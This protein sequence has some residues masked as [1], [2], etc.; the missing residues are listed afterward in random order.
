MS[1]AKKRNLPVVPGAV[2]AFFLAACPAAA[3]STTTAS[4]P[5]QIEQRVDDKQPRRPAVLEPHLDILPKSQVTSTADKFS[6]V[7][8]AVIID[9]ATAFSRADLAPLYG[10]YLARK[11][12][13]VEVQEIA[14]AVTQVYRDAGYVFSQADVPVQDV[15]AGVLKIRVTEG[16]VAAVDYGADGPAEGI[17]AAY[18]AP[19]LAE[20]PVRLETIERAMLL[21]NDLPGVTIADASIADGDGPGARVLKL[22]LEE[23]AV[24]AELY[25]D[26]RGTPSSGRLQTWASASANG[27]LSTGDKLQAGLFTI[28]DAPRELLYGMVRWTQPLGSLGTTGE[29]T[30]SG[31]KADAGADLADNDT[32][33]DS[34]RLL[35]SLRHPLLRTRKD[36]LW[37]LAEF[38]IYDVN[39]DTQGATSYEDR[40][41]T[42]R[43]GMEFYLSEALNGDFYAKAM[44][45]R[46]LDIL[47]A[48]NPGNGQLS[49]S[50][51]KATF[52]KV[53]LEVRRLQKLWGGFGLY[54]QA[55]GQ[56]A[57]QPLLT[58]AEFSLGGSQY[59]RAYDYGEV[60]G[61]RGA[62]AS[63]ELRYT[64]KKPADWI[65]SFDLYGFYDGGIAWNDGARRQ[66]LTSAGAGLR[67]TFAKGFYADL[68]V[69]KPLNHEVSTEADKDLRILFAIG[70]G[71]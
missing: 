13:E 43:L 39:E 2:V 69:A 31:S 55:K 54:A 18:L 17:V 58:A 25:M 63:V 15:L 1:V 71:L 35:L 38:D 16:Y 33:T 62:A 34:R 26:N 47:G 7:L 60:V 46:G 56:W 67:G 14:Q 5:T 48:S 51:G 20:R 68:Q 11:V 21:V 42:A 28:P 4:D 59:G 49:R 53:T 40:N 10:K 3:Q 22:K 6:F 65:E 45:A 30:L 8:S 64:G 52:D 36:S 41:R 9:G 66:V 44:Y 19:V 29:L 24:N 37:A 27:V 70:A 61:D 12:T 57:N 32:E 23:Q 50:D